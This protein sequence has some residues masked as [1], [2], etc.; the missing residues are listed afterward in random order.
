[1]IKKI[2]KILLKMKIEKI[3]LKIASFARSYITCFLPPLFTI[4]N[5]V[6]LLE[7]TKNSSKLR[8]FLIFLTVTYFSFTLYLSTLKF[9]KKI[10]K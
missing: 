1:M 9:L 7:E 4:V 10:K 6:D 5:Y 8:I 2:E 3:L